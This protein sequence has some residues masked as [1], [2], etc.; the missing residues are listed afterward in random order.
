M[1]APDIYEVGP[2]GNGWFH[3]TVTAANGK[4]WMQGNFVSEKAALTWVKRHTRA[5]AVDIGLTGQPL[6]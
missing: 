6:P 4:S 2:S 1:E 3:V 5:A